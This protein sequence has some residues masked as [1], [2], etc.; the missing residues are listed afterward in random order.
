MLEL[1]CITPIAEATCSTGGSFGLEA[2]KIQ[3]IISHSHFWSRLK[4]P[5]HVLTQF[6]TAMSSGVIA[7]ATKL[8]VAIYYFSGRFSI[9]MQR[10]KKNCLLPK[11]PAV[12]LTCMK[13]NS[14]LLK[15]T[16][17]AASMHA[18]LSEDLCSVCQSVAA[19][20]MIL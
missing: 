6:I 14:E 7:K 3:T 10:K 15:Q 8:T 17:K 11:I 16:Y 5:L 2:P 13:H 1:L 4:L 9:V 12:K 20:Q 18:A 19:C